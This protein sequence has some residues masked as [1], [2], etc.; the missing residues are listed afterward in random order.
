MKVKTS[1]SL[2]AECV[3]ELDAL[4]DEGTNRSALIEEAVVQFIERRRRRSR[5]A[6]DREI[7]AAHAKS[8]EQDVR[9]TLEFQAPE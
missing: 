9:E 6:K 1:V 3:R 7:I 2:S 5:G 8:L 4:T